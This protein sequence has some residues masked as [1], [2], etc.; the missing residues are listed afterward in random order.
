MTLRK[1]WIFLADHEW[2]NELMRKLA[3]E[4]FAE[5]PDADAVEV[6]EH[7]GWWLTFRR[8]MQCVASANDCACFPREV[9]EWWKQWDD[10]RMIAN[11]RRDRPTPLGLVAA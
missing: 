1:V 10:C 2:G 4:A 5:F 6:H 9:D 11:I 8:Y 7:A 3:Q